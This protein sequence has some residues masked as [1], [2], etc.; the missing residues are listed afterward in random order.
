MW[1]CPNCSEECE[2]NFDRCWN[3]GTEQEGTSPETTATETPGVPST[4]SAA[5]IADLHQHPPRSCSGVYDKRRKMASWSRKRAA[6]VAAMGLAEIIAWRDCGY[7]FQGFDAAL[8]RV[9]RH[10][11]MNQLLGDL[12]ALGA[13]LLILSGV[14]VVLKP[15]ARRPV[16]IAAL[17][18]A[19]VTL[20]TFAISV[21]LVDSIRSGQI[22]PVKAIFYVVPCLVAVVVSRKLAFG[23]PIPEPVGCDSD[24]KVFRS[25]APVD[26]NVVPAG[27][28]TKDE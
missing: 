9:D 8:W 17:V 13:G 26:P 23:R 2:D 18:I 20:L 5:P 27:N 19:F 4:S 7:R 24:P 21:D 11:A 6:I 15:Q 25:A 10:F 3:C 16:G 12:P 22:H 1:L 14:I 28:V